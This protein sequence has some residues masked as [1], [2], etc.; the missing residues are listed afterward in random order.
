MFWHGDIITI[1]KTIDLMSQIQIQIQS[2][3]QMTAIAPKSV[4][5]NYPMNASLIMRHGESS[6]Q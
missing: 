3:F 5:N 1:K 2:V 6:N 4:S